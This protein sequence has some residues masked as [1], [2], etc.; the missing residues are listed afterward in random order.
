MMESASPTAANVEQELKQ[1]ALDT[2]CQV[3]DPAECDM[4]TPKEVSNKDSRDGD[5]IVAQLES[6]SV[7]LDQI[8]RSIGDLT[9]SIKE[10]VTSRTK[11][12]PAAESGE[13]S[14]KS[15]KEQKA[16][17]KVDGDI[18]T[19]EE[20]NG[21]V[22]SGK[23]VPQVRNC[24]WE[25]FKNR[26][27]GGEEV[28]ALEVLNTGGSLPRQMEDENARRARIP[29]RKPEVPSDPEDPTPITKHGLAHSE[30]R[31]GSWIQQVRIN[32]KAVMKMLGKLSDADKPWEGKPHTFHQP[33]RLLLHF[34]EKIKEELQIIE[35]K[36]AGSSAPPDTDLASLDEATLKD[37]APASVA[38]DEDTNNKK[39]QESDDL[40]AL[41]L[42]K[43]TLEEVQC[44]VNFVEER[45]L[46]LR[47][48]F[49]NPT[50]TGVPKVGYED[51]SYLFEPGDLVYVP[52]S[53]QQG[54]SANSTTQEIRRLFRVH[55]G[56]NKELLDGCSCSICKVQKFTSIQ[57]YYLDYD[58][59]GYGCV[60]TP[61][62]FEPFAGK[63]LITELPCY[64]LRFVEDRE[65]KL[66][67]AKSDG[68]RFVE[69]ISKRYGFYNGWSVIKSPAG[70]D[71]EDAKG[72]RIKS[73]EHIESD[74]LVD[75]TE[76]S[77]VYPRWKPELT[78]Q[79]EDI[80][81]L[82][83][84]SDDT[85]IIT[86][87]GS[88][89]KDLLRE[90][91]DSL[92]DD[93]LFEF[94]EYNAY[95]KR[96]AFLAKQHNQAPTGEDLVLLP[97]RMFAYAVGDRKFV[98]ID[99]RY[100]KPVK[101]QG[102]E[103]EAFGDL[104]IDNKNKRLIE[105]LLKSHF[106]KKKDES[107]GTE[108]LS[109][110]LIRGKGRGIVIL[111]HGEPG[112]GKTATAEAV[113]QKYEKPLFP[114]TCGDLG[115]TPEGVEKS[116]KEFFRLAHLWDCVLLL[117]E[118]EVF[119]SQ[120]DKNDLQRN[121][122][123][124][125]FLRMLEYY[126]GVLFLTTNRVGVL[127][128]AIKSRVHLHLRYNQ[129]DRQ[130]TTEIFKHNIIRLKNIELQRQDAADRLYIIESEINEFA[131][132]HFDETAKSGVGRW[133]GR[134]IR[135][136]FL[137]AASLAHLDGE[138]N[139]GMQKQLRK[140]HFD[141]V[142]QTT[143][144]YDSFRTATLGRDDSHLA[145]EREERYDGFDPRSSIAMPSNP[146]GHPSY[147]PPHR[148]GPAGYYAAPTTQYERTNPMGPPGHMPKPAT[149]VAHE[150]PP[151]DV[152]Y[153]R[154]YEAGSRSSMGGAEWQQGQYP[155]QQYG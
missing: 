147:A 32:S 120:R 30:V 84:V 48:Q 66:K 62:P 152:G 54:P 93:S 41:Y 125:V 143:K 136:A 95:I 31:R 150:Q 44:Y 43:E 60:M 99:S 146:Y 113:A 110:D 70:D 40:E 36:V 104:Q 72:D 39:E 118:A 73:P 13:P 148:T 34:H 50:A 26:D 75:F 109:Q 81:T 47:Q 79:E 42:K 23:I 35:T 101:Q 8:N 96:D 80:Y 145:H 142:A 33:F 55:V 18:S 71:L 116:L 134:Q 21:V 14:A 144:L 128:E 107:E 53:G 89:R 127:D 12:A 20:S 137:I 111:L 24:N 154:Q 138:K 141:D 117:D 63:K 57:S 83:L 6:G 139:P 45:L 58:G 16:A 87:K 2:V 76:A 38:D 37:T 67:H 5:A 29:G 100:L 121:A 15:P 68:S 86:W 133:N 151:S 124:S 114:I 69:H 115:F 126:N 11:Q 91:H 155:S 92:M 108:V 88:D 49:H 64:P 77:N 122:L 103:G 3:T 132:T 82:A 135:N 153:S 97:R 106:R 28:F 59:E 7:S 65:T 130:Q 22:F 112:V 25:Q 1:P 119:I 85:S 90:S 131:L 10:L 78:K 98:H 123:V 61:I 9:S 129:L 19:E 105:S 51:L 102:K 17:T 46:P 74:V 4:A 27:D 94:L 149:P 140:M 56:Y 52:K